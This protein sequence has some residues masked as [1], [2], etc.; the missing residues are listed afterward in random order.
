MTNKLSAF[1]SADRAATELIDGN[2]SFDFRAFLGKVGPAP[3]R[4][5]RKREAKQDLLAGSKQTQRN[6]QDRLQNSRG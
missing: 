1:C 5:M 2:V 4:V 6:S 3:S